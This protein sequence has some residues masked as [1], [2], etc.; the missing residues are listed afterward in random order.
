MAL[1]AGQRATAYDLV[2]TGVWTPRLNPLELLVRFHQR[3]GGGNLLLELGAPAH[4]LPRS[5]L[6]L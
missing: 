5:I 3:L 2:K 1:L 4:D 6:T